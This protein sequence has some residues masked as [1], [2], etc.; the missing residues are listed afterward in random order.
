MIDGL[1]RNQDTFRFNCTVSL[2]SVVAA[3]RGH[4]RGLE[5]APGFRSK[6]NVDKKEVPNL[7]K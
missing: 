7:G 2:N 3:D 6:G 1:S 4:K 5:L